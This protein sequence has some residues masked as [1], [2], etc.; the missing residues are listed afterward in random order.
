[1]FVTFLFSIK[2]FGNLPKS[3]I[4]TLVTLTTAKLVNIIVVNNNNNN[5][6]VIQMYS[7]SPIISLQ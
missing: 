6:I 7:W 2:Y 1:M 3:V 4:S 5:N